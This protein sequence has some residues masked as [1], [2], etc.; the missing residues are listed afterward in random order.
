[1]DN[2]IAWLEAISPMPEQLFYNTVIVHTYGLLPTI[3]KRS[4]K[5]SAVI[6]VPLS[7]LP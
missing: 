5:E 6:D 1:V 4:E 3:K 7:G 2:R